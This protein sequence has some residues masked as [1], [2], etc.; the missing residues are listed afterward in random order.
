MILACKDL[1]HQLHPLHREGDAVATE[2]QDKDGI[3]E[4]GVFPNEGQPILCH[5]EST[6][7]GVIFKEG[8]GGEQLLN[9]F[10][11]LVP[12]LAFHLLTHR[13][14]FVGDVFTTHQ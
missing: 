10:D 4:I 7:P 13:V 12:F 6:C 8:E 2:S 3:W 5:T 1:K 11:Q 9:L 14:V